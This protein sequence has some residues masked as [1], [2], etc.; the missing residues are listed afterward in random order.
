M[1][2]RPLQEGGANAPPY[3]EADDED[4]TED[5]HMQVRAS[6][7]AALWHSTCHWWV[8]SRAGRY[9]VLCAAFGAI[10][11]MWEPLILYLKSNR[12]TCALSLTVKL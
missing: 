9:Q 6:S 4:M 8:C 12:T 1:R 10:P 5:E 11:S 7:T 2:W 3:G